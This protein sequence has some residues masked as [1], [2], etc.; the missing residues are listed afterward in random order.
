MS[1]RLVHHASALYGLT[2]DK[3]EIVEEVKWK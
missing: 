1:A 2:E 3:I